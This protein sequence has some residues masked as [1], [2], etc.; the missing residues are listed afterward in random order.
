MVLAI[1]G[2]LPE[3]FYLDQ[4]ACDNSAFILFVSE[5]EWDVEALYLA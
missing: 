4:L 3:M 2:Q 5:T 1:C